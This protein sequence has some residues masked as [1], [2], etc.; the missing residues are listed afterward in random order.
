MSIASLL[1]I[2]WLMSYGS[3]CYGLVHVSFL[4][5]F[6]LTN[7]D[8]TVA[9]IMHKAN[10]PKWVEA[11]CKSKSKRYFSKRRRRN[12]T[13]KHSRCDKIVIDVNGGVLFSRRD[14]VHGMQL[15]IKAPPSWWRL[16][17]RDNPTTQHL[18]ENTNPQNL[19]WQ[20]KYRQGHK[21]GNDETTEWQRR[22]ERQ[23]R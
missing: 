21:T 11:M 16:R 5:P 13:Y 19:S 22:N 1:W 12:T 23:R 17:T 4:C 18:K 9:S 14:E 2:V 10:V 15:I 3:C 8:P 6:H 7:I 20:W